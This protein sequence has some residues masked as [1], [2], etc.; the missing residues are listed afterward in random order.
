MPSLVSSVEPLGQTELARLTLQKQG[1]LERGGGSAV[2][3]AGRLCGLHAQ[4]STTPPL[5]LLARVNGFQKETLERALHRRSLIKRWLMRG[6][7][8][9][10]PARDLPIYHH[11]LR[12]AWILSLGKFLERQGLPPRQVRIEKIYPAVL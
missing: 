5:A 8:H 9:I 1:L 6:T 11:A 10:T 7:L 3:W 12:R 4:L 2:H